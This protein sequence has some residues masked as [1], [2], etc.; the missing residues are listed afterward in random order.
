MSAAWFNPTNWTPYGVP[1]ADDVVTIVAGTVDIPGYAFTDLHVS[2]G[3][4][5][6]GFAVAGTMVW[7]GGSTVPGA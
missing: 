6:G 1:M 5:R 4:L 2:G 3:T 7:T